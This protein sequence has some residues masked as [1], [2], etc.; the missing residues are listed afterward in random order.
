MVA[1]ALAVA[2][3]AVSAFPVAAAQ[4]PRFTE[5]REAAALH[6]VKKHCPELSPLLDDLKRANRSAYEQQVRETFRVT[7]LLADIQEDSKRYE[8]QLS[9][10]KAENKALVL[11][12]KLAA[13]RDDDRKAVEQ[14]LQALAKELVGLEVQSLEY[15]SVV[16]ERELA[17][18]KGELAKA[19]ENFDRTVKGKFDEFIEK[20]RK[21]RG[22]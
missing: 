2:L 22:S 3:L 9:L 7:E 8:L 21:R 13:P 16:L 5:E 14:Q 1:R 20:A 6:F 11:V 18:T 17:E 12:A 10:W 4:P 15:Q 19:R